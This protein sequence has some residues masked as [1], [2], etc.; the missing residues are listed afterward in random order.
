[1]VDFSNGTT[2]INDTN[3]NK[4]QSDLT[5]DYISVY[6]SNTQSFSK[7]TQSI[8]NFNTT[9]LGINTFNLSSNKIVCNKAGVIA[10]AYKIYLNS[11]FA[12]QDNIIVKLYKNSNE[13]DR[14][15]F[16]PNGSASQTITSNIIIDSVSEDDTIHLELINYSNNTVTGNTSAIN[17]N[18]LNIHYLEK[19]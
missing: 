1:M 3:L 10:I 13:I 6:N 4:A 8:V 15:Q 17:A 12:D 2:P 5:N 7:N 14:L 16:R 18:A 9:Y 19:E 11:R